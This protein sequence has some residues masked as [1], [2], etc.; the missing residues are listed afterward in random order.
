MQARNKALLSDESVRA[1][2]LVTGLYTVTAA[3]AS[4]TNRTELWGGVQTEQ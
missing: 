1:Q 2:W 4:R 3:T